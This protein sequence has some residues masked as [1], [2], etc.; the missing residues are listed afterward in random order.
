M[1]KPS[2]RKTFFGKLV[3]LLA[4]AGTAPALL[5]RLSPTSPASS[6]SGFERNKAL[7]FSIKPDLRA[8]ARKAD[9]V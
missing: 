8:V 6:Q 2:S 4:A 5:A 9:S 1:T 3:A 7:P